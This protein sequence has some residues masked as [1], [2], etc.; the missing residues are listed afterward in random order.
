MAGGQTGSSV[1]RIHTARVPLRALGALAVSDGIEWIEAAMVCLPA[2]DTSMP[3]TGADLV[4][5]TYGYKGNGVLI[6]I[7]DT[8]IDYTHEDFR[9]SDGSTRIKAI[10]DQTVSTGA[11]SSPT[12]YTYGREWSEA[13]I[14][15]ELVASPPGT[16]TEQD[17]NGHGTHVTGISAGNGRATGNS[18]AAGRH[19]GMAPEADILVIKGGDDSFL[20]TK[21]QDGVAWAISKAAGSS[22]PIVINLSL[23]GHSGAHD[24]TSNYE[25][26]L[27]SSLGTGKVIV[28]AAGDEGSDNIHDRTSL[29]AAMT[30]VDSFSITVAY[31][32][33][34]EA[35]TGNDYAK[36]ESWHN[37]SAAVSITVRAPDGTTT[38][39]P[40]SQGGSLDL[41]LASGHVTIQ[42]TSSPVTVNSDHQAIIYID[43]A[44][45]GQEP[46][47]GDWWIIYE[48]SSGT[49]AT[50]DTWIY[51]TSSLDA[52]VTG[53][54][55]S[56][57]VGMPATAED[58]I[59]VG[60]FVTKWS[61]PA[62]DGQNWGYPGTDRT[63][64]YASF[65]SHGPT[66]DGRTK[67]EITAPGQG[68]ARPLR[69]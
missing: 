43:D 50:I 47:A 60:A 5:G 36:L 39:G 10:W 31:D 14:N 1:G 53:G 3:A 51:E 54:D 15:A 59:T 48:L 40:V 32:G 8:G 20:S 23:G 65:S 33:A 34:V 45:A 30:D 26:Y 42:S 7:Y 38:Y 58:I 16:V 69:M 6:A 37:G 61:W 62:I 29:T 44:T 63:G 46:M 28:A 11:G 55:A 18:I 4:H 24:G 17:I 9:N 25:Q 64:D 12:G 19:V 22:Q 67:P 66:R 27:D 56:Y 52:E 41:D 49:T 68:K 21:V 13:D 35:G 2:L 57:S